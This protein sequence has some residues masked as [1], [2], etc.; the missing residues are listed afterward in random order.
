[1]APALVL[2]EEKAREAGLSSAGPYA[3]GVAFPGVY[4]VG[5][6]V[7]IS[8]LGGLTY[9]EAIALLE[10]TG[11]PLEETEVAEGEGK[12]YRE[13]HAASDLEVAA[14]K[15]DEA[16]EE[17]GGIRTHAQ[18]DE[19]AAELGIVWPEGKITLAEK[20]A[21]IEAVR[22]GADPDAAAAESAADGEE[23]TPDG[24]EPPA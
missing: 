6:P 19:V 20:V 11:V 16:V 10:E 7:A 15:V 4:F 5:R 23:A 12:A 14:A 22:A 3:F 18:A 2:T 13:N 21:A 17:A 8:E 1:M 9:D 24:E